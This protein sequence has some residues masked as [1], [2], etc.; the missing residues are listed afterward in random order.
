VYTV[1]GPQ[2]HYL[3]ANEE[4]MLSLPRGTP[5]LGKSSASAARGGAEG[6]D[7]GGGGGGAL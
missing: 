4:R 2:Q 6:G 3:V 1:I 5:G 7:A